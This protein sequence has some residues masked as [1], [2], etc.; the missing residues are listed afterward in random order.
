MNNS[1]NAAV[2]DNKS[3]LTEL[4]YAWKDENQNKSVTSIYLRVEQMLKIL[5][6]DVSKMNPAL[7]E[8]IRQKN[9]WKNRYT[10][11]LVAW[12]DFCRYG[13]NKMP[14]IFT[15]K[16]LLTKNSRN[17]VI[18]LTPRMVE[19]IKAITDVHVVRATASKLKTA[20]IDRIMASF[21]ALMCFVKSKDSEREINCLSDFTEQDVLDFKSHLFATESSPLT[22][23]K[24]SYNSLTAYLIDLRRVFKM[25]YTQ[26]KLKDNICRE[27]P[28][29]RH[30]TVKRTFCLDKEQINKLRTVNDGVIESMSLN[31]QFEQV[32]NNTMVSVQYEGALR[33]EEVTRLCFE[34]IPKY[35]RAKSNVGPIVVRGSKARPAEHE[36][37][38]YILFDRLDM[39]LAKWNKVKDLFCMSRN[40]TPPVINRNGK[41]YHPIFFSAK[42]DA[43]C[44]ATYINC[45]F[46]S[47]IEK[48]KISLPKGYKT[49]ILR[50][51]RIT[52]WVDD[53]NY[54]FEKVHQNARHANL[55]ETWGYFHSSSRKRIEA[56][57]KIEKVDSESSRLKISRLPEKGILRKI[58]EIA[59]GKTNPI[60]ENKNALISEIVQEVEEKCEDY[61]EVDQ[62]YTY[63][64]IMD[65]WGL[66]RTQTWERLNI[67]VKQG[68]LEVVEV[69]GKRMYPRK[70]IDYISS[71][72]DSKKAT[73]SFG[74][75]QK[76][77]ITIAN[78]ANKGIIKSTKI[79]KLHYFEPGELIDH[80]FH[81]KSK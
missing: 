7:F 29:E 47:Q 51:S 5:N 12:N 9:K 26:R 22:G 4:L 44:T 75:K 40:I 20:S 55:D 70:G 63:R 10:L 77:P 28:I 18:S 8:S 39:D 36:D 73:I 52:H 19:E 76:V 27:I 61:L 78:M 57:E 3:L 30:K 72:V 66:S 21:T 68:M 46:G 34:D 25:G 2:T 74:Y 81:K 38:V 14:G 11:P 65:I 33:A 35:E 59:I 24:V 69:K 60:P 67:L 41:E 16:A 31:E 49:H 64:Q 32:R 1:M 42:G 79:G 53:D 58:I 50:H 54:P 45:I 48:A 13:V 43:L 17:T 71:L 56:V 15:E 6:Y 37:R 80:F 62:Y 23:N